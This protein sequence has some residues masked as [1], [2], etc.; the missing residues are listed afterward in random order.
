[1]VLPEVSA[2]LAGAGMGLPGAGAGLPGA[3]AGLPRGPLAAA[4]PSADEERLLSAQPPF[5]P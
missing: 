1:M 4:E 3:G 5:D 2:G